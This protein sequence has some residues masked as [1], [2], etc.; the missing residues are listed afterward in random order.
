MVWTL[1]K[2]RVISVV[3]I[4]G[5]KAKKNLVHLVTGGHG[6][7]LHIASVYSGK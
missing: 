3:A 2:N 4:G 7:S 5:K 6:N 1:S